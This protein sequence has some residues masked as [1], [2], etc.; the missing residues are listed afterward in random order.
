MQAR[1]LAHQLGHH[2]K[3]K[4]VCSRGE[5]VG[6]EFGDYSF[7]LLSLFGHMGKL[8]VALL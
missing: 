7:I 5:Q 8:Q 6:A 1:D 2:L 3:V 4:V